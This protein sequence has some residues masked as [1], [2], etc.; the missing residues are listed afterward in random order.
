MAG[1]A[2]PLACV[3][4]VKVPSQLLRSSDLRCGS[5]PM[6]RAKPEYP[7]AIVVVVG[8]NQVQAAQLIRSARP[9]VLVGKRAVAIVV[10]I[11]HRAQAS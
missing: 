1:I 3:T 9:G 8:L 7:A 6:L 2:R 5:A 4:S 10:E 11:V